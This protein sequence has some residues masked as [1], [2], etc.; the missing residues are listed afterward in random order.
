MV[1]VINEV[2]NYIHLTF[3]THCTLAGISN[4]RHDALG[5]LK[6]DYLFII[7]AFITYLVQLMYKLQLGITI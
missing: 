3:E 6:I 5:S 2:Q 7:N 1:V 4:D